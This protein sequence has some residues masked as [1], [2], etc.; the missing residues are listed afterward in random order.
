[1]TTTPSDAPRDTSHDQ[2]IQLDA[3]VSHHNGS[4]ISKLV[5]SVWVLVAAFAF[6]LLIAV[7]I[8]GVFV[9]EVHD[10]RATSDRQFKDL[11]CISD[12]ATQYTSRTQALL[13]TNLTRVSAI[14]QLVVTVLD[15][16]STQAQRMQAAQ[17][18]VKASRDY[19]AQAKASP[20]PP[21]PEF[22]CFTERPP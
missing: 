12:W 13:E 6:A 18:Y 10:Q 19:Q 14:D 3:N 21:A 9:K 17:E 4:S 5:R 7:A 1:M 8:G 11:Q 20:I 16:K 22:T 2:H 15:T